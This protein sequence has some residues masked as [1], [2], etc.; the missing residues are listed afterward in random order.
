MHNARLLVYLFTHLLMKKL[1]LTLSLALVAIASWAITEQEAVDAYAARKGMRHASSGVV[2]IDIDSN[3]VIAGH[4][5]DQAIV[6]ASTMK[7]VTTVAALE[8]LGGNFRFKTRVYLQGD[9][10]GDTLMGRVLIVG[11]GDPTLGSHYIKGNPNIVN[12]IV[13]AIKQRGI[14]CIAGHVA[15]DETLYPYPPYSIHWDVGDLAWDYGAAVHTLN[16][17][18]NVMKV[19]FSV[20]KWGR[21]SPFRL[22]PNV[23]GVEVINRMNYRA[24]GE[25]L[26]FALEY[27][28]PGLVLMGDV[29]PGRYNLTASNPSPAALLADSVTHALVRQGISMIEGDDLKA[30]ESG[31][32]DL[33]LTH[34]SVELT[35]IVESLL[36]RSDNMFTHALLRAVAI[37]NGW[38][39]GSIDKAGVDGVKRV[40]KSLG[41]DTDALFMRDGSGLARAGKAS[42][43]LLASMLTAVA[44]KEY[45]GRRLCDLMP[46]AGNRVGN[47]LGSHRLARQ[48]VLKSGSMT[49]VQC[50]VGYYP[51]DKP[52]YAFALLA[53]NYTCS[54][55]DLR[56]HMSRLLIDL[57]GNK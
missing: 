12:E 38:R 53:N 56:A 45:N 48:I 19:N 22:T 1:L 11:G 50:Y 21:F 51:A 34:E 14:H 24:K 27:G 52:R 9:V 16:F 6:T 33:L 7:T 32:K 3:K 37:H 17:A 54:R 41:V 10:K 47:V 20:D 28:T 43:Y 30:M 36:D 31:H 44:F 25:D 39:S 57:F 4:L 42:P 46:K 55:A 5:Q 49:D 29:C 40:L 8:T 2:V 18:D 35:D 15:T 23:P 13:T 26:D